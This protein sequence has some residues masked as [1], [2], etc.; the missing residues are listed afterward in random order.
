M[1]EDTFLC[2]LRGGDPDICGVLYTGRRGQPTLIGG[3]VAAGKAAA[4]GP[5][6]SRSWSGLDAGV[7]GL[8]E[9]AEGL[10]QCV[11]ERVAARLQCLLWLLGV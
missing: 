7:Q 3:S 10:P 9:F 4:S 1:K 2:A 11:S 5:G 8:V 6:K